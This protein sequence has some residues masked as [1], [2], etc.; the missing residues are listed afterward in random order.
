MFSGSLDVQASLGK[1]ARSGYSHLPKSS[2]H[3]PE[4]GAAA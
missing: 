4:Q 1:A 2:F 3:N